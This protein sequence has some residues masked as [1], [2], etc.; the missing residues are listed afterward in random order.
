MQGCGSY[1]LN[2]CSDSDYKVTTFVSKRDGIRCI[3]TL[4]C[5]WV[6][7]AHI[8]V[9][10]HSEQFFYK[11]SLCVQR[12]QERAT[13]RLSKFCRCTAWRSAHPIKDLRFF[14]LAL[15]Q[16]DVLLDV[17]LQNV[18]PLHVLLVYYS[19]EYGPLMTTE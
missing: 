3:S 10:Y 19:S 7:A 8:G 9:S 11:V 18:P 13:F 14:I 6:V 4:T 17:L 12:E 16:L 2:I 5:F 1:P 15:E